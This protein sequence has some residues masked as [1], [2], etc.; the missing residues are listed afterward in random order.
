[1]SIL[2]H[3]ATTR[4]L[5]LLAVTSLFASSVLA[6]A[7]VRARPHSDFK[8]AV[9][10]QDRLDLHRQDGPKVNG[11]RIQIVDFEREADKAN[12]GTIAYNPTFIDTQIHGRPVTVLAARI[13]SLNGE[14]DTE[15]RFFEQDTTGV[16]RAIPNAPIFKL[17]D[18][19]N[20]II[21]GELVFGGVHAYEDGYD[22]VN[23]RVIVNYETVF[24]RDFKKG[25]MSIDPKTEFARGPSHMKDIRLGER[26]LDGKSEIHLFTRPQGHE[27]GRGVIGHKVIQSLNDL[28]NLSTYADGITIFKDLWPEKEWGGINSVTYLKEQDKFVLFGHQ[29]RYT[30]PPGSKEETRNYASFV[31]K[32]DP[33]T[34]EFHNPLIIAERSQFEGGVKDGS[35][36]P[37]LEDVIFSGHIR[38]LPNGDAEILVGGG[39]RHIY[40]AIIPRVLQRLG[41][42]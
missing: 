16:Y 23:K 13:E 21:D 19:F 10:L 18:P 20:T 39:D 11:K 6:G 29:A 33:A 34:S 8:C 30:D 40:W 31:L 26:T 36:R 12:G 35:K 38:F 25:L 24:Y 1:M 4:V 41:L 28:K 27:F 9:P 32:F 14:L 5:I 42:N 37:D 15:T 3:R 7:L 17:Q 22:A 2:V